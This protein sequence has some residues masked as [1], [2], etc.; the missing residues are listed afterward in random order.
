MRVLGKCDASRARDAVR[1]TRVADR[2]DRAAPRGS[3]GAAAP[4]RGDSERDPPGDTAG[5]SRRGRDHRSGR[6]R[7]AAGTGGRPASG[8]SPRPR[9]PGEIRWAVDTRAGV[10]DNRG[11]PPTPP[12]G[13][14]ARGSGGISSRPSPFSLRGRGSLPENQS[15][16]YS[17]RQSVRNFTQSGERQQ[18]RARM[19]RVL[20][21]PALHGG[22]QRPQRVRLRSGPHL[23]PAQTSGS[24]RRVSHL[25]GFLAVRAVRSLPVADHGAAEGSG[26]CHAVKVI[27]EP[28]AGKP[29]VR[30]DE[31]VLA[32]GHGRAREAPPDERGGNS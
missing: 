6:G 13:G 18:R 1:D 26:V 5:C 22:L 4:R 16:F 14:C 9:G 28:D 8:G 11:K 27:G 15:P 31:G 10:C 7:R 30:F 12:R 24:D 20:L 3:A 17:Q 19:G 32:F 29:H 25:P 21:L 2:D 23:P